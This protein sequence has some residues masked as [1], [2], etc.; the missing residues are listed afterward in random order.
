MYVLN[1]VFA[2]PV[3]PFWSA[4]FLFGD[5]DSLVFK[6][7]YDLLLPGSISET[8]TR[9]SGTFC[10]FSLMSGAV[11]FKPCFGGIGVTV[12]E[13]CLDGSYIHSLLFQM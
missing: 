13:I 7:G 12:L 8:K 3:F 11:I 2:A 10:H 9:T 6:S 1:H 4:V 5:I